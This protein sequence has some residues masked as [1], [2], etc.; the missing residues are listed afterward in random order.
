MHDVQESLPHRIVHSAAVIAAVCSKC[1]GALQICLVIACGDDSRSLSPTRFCTTETKATLYRGGGRRQQLHPGP[2]QSQ[3][4]TVREARVHA[5]RAGST[6]KRAGLASPAVE[7]APPH[8]PTFRRDKKGEPALGNR[9]RAR[10]REVAFCG[11]AVRSPPTRKPKR[12][13]RHR[14]EPSRVLEGIVQ[15]QLGFRPRSRSEL[16]SRAAAHCSHSVRCLWVRRLGVR[17]LTGSHRP[18]WRKSRC[19]SW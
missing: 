14:F 12:A 8:T 15:Q 3:E 4:A 10:M 5:S 6:T 13:P 11:R 9:G 18:H 7:R 16:D 19:G 17:S 1:H 2:Q